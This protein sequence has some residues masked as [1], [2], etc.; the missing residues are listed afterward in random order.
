MQYPPVIQQKLSNARA[1]DVSGL[2]VYLILR[3][4][5]DQI[6]ETGVKPVSQSK[7]ANDGLIHVLTGTQRRTKLE[8][9]CPV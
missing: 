4:V 7:G 3:I 8:I 2:G 6:K 5:G 9:L 1:I